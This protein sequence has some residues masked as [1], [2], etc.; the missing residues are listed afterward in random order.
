MLANR[1]PAPSSPPGSPP[2]GPMQAATHRSPV[3]LQDLLDDLLWPQL[4]KSWKLALAPGR[5]ALCFIAVLVI[6]ALWAVTKSATGQDTLG[7]LW[8]GIV[9]D[10]RSIIG[11]FSGPEAATLA[12]YSL[13]IE[14]PADFVRQHPVVA[15][16]VI[17][18]ILFVWCMVGGAVCRS[19]AC[20]VALRAALPWRQAIGFGLKK[21]L[22]LFAALAGPLLLVWG[23]CLLLRVMG[24]ALFTTKALGLLGGATFIAPLLL[25]LIISVALFA[26]LLAHSLLIPAV[27]CEGTDSFDAVQRC[28]AYALARPGRLVGYTIISV[29]SVIPAMVIV[30]VIVAF[31]IIAAAALTGAPLAGPDAV[32]PEP[33]RPGGGEHLGFARW[34]VRAWTVLFVSVG[35]AYFVSLYFCA[36]TNLY[37][38]IR[39]LVDGQDISEIWV[40]QSAPVPTAQQA[41]T[42]IPVPEKADYT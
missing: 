25:C 9:R 27:A 8:L 10:F 6:G 13:F 28:Y 38:V 16:A 39:R 17:P 42:P 2:A 31:A 18:A 36:A 21:S 32:F 14:T 12:V 22:A 23:A 29:F 4:L 24:L 11:V 33:F 34:M 7:G 40:P 37:L 15:L 1:P 3:T 41:A 5:V 35:L 20:E 19:C 30:G 26:Y